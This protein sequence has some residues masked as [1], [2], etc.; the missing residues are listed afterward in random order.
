VRGEERAGRRE[1][2]TGS[3][4][5]PLAPPRTAHALLLGVGC[6]AGEGTRVAAH[7]VSE[8]EQ[9]ERGKRARFS[10]A[11]VQEGRA[12]LLIYG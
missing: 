3:A 6:D 7:G 1:R 8:S 9:E 11:T 2:S 4:A 10:S 5:A 12:Q